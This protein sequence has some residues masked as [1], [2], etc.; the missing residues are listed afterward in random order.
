MP[1]SSPSA[2][3]AVA[4][5]WSRSTTGSRLNERSRSSPIV[6]RVRV[7]AV[8]MISTARSFSP[9][10]TKSVAA[11]SSSA[12]PASDCT[13]PSW[14]KRAMRRRSSCSAARTCSVSS[15]TP[16][17]DDRFAQRDRDGLRP[18]V[19]LELREDVAHVALHGLLADE[20][21]RRDVG[22]R[23][24]VG[25]ELEDLPLPRREHVVLVLAHEERGHQGRVDVALAARDLLDRAEE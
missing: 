9:R 23:H 13:G 3:T 22:V 25:E 1:F 24:P 11:S 19:R 5:P 15:A 18:R 7:S 2:L 17:I 8:S 21:L 12:T 20:E 10:R 16:L 6:V 14:R 4:S